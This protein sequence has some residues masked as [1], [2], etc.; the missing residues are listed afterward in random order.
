[1]P[2]P[3][4]FDFGGTLDA[5]GQPWVERFFRGYRAVGGRLAA[6]AF[7]ERFRISDRLLATTP[8]IAELGLRAMVERQ[9]GLLRGLLP[10]GA[11]VDGA[12]W[13]GGFLASSHATAARNQPLLREL[14]GSRPLGVVSNFTGNLRPCLEE[15]GLLDC[16]DVVLDSTEIG[17]RKPD[18]RLFDVAFR[19]LAVGAEECWMVGDNPVADIAAA[20]QLGCSTCWLAPAERPLPEG[21]RPD[22][23]IAALTDLP[24]VLA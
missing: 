9:V 5:D 16:F 8:G 6:E 3:V 10:D 23:R 22:R 7:E 15:L 1:M 11:A 12:M 21:L 20:G 14:A 4:L 19:A 2:G 24:V 17:V 18:G 13:A